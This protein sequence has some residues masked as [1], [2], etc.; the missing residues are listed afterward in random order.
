[1]K[2]VLIFILGMIMIVVLFVIFSPSY[3]VE[4][5]SFEPLIKIVRRQV[6]YYGIKKVIFAFSVLAPLKEEITYRSAVWLFCFISLLLKVK[7]EWQRVI[8]LLILF[9]PTMFWTMP[10]HYPAFYQCCVFLGGITSGLFTIYLMN[11]KNGWW[12]TLFLPILLHGIFN[13]CFILIVWKFLL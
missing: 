8:A 1:M 5:F 11:R 6:D 7:S 2:K 10:H 9:I 12:I 3:Y 13:F 4:I